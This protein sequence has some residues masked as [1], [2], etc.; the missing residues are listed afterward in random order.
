MIAFPISAY[1]IPIMHFKWDLK[2]PSY[3]QIKENG[4]LA[5]KCRNNFGCKKR[6]NVENKISRRILKKT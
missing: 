4:H 5:K 2:Y 6:N 1:H 3:N